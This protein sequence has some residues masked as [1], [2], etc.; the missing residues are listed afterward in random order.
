MSNT[1][2]GTAF[3][4]VFTALLAAAQ[5]R[6]LPRPLE[7]SAEYAAAI[8]DGRRAADGRPGPAA[9]TDHTRYVITAELEPALNLVRGHVAMTYGNRSG[10]AI[11]DLVIH[12]RQDLHRQGA[13]RNIEAEITGGMTIDRLTLN[14]GEAMHWVDGTVLTIQL[15]DE[16]AAGAEARVEMDFSFTVPNGEAPR[17]GRETDELF[18]LGYWYPQFAVHDDIEGWVAE[19]YLGTSEFYMPYGDYEVAFTVPA[20]YLVQATGTLTNA[21]EVLTAAT[22]ERLAAAATAKEPVAIITAEDHAAGTVTAAADNGARLTWRFTAT[23]VRDF[24]ISAA[25]CYLWDAVAAEVGDR[26]GDGKPD[27][28]LVNT[29]YRP[30]ARTY[31]RGARYA[32][33]AIEWMSR[34]IAPYPWP[35]ATVVE[36]ILG[37][38]M[39]YPMIVLCGDVPIPHEL[40]GLIAHELAH[41]WFPMLVG[42]NEKANA[43]QDE[44][45]VEFCTDL[46][47][48]DHDG[49]PPSGL[50][51]LAEYRFYADRGIDR[52]PL[53]R[54]SDHLVHESSYEFNGYT[55]PA[56]L[57]HQ[58]AGMF[59]HATVLGALSRYAAAWQYRHPRP[60]DFFRSMNAALGRDLDWYWSGWWGETWTL[61]HAIGSVRPTEDGNGTVVEIEDRGNAFL[62]AMVEVRYADGS[63][64]R[65]TV[66]ESTW[67]A[68]ARSATLVFG[69]DVDEVT[70][71]PQQTSLDVDPANNSWARTR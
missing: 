47:R 16:L 19:Q 32:S 12:L 67:L 2:T 42:S 6:P 11:E 10:E 43:W 71:D 23:G 8:A 5:D 40:Q 37:G 62:P 29:L 24:A 48:A 15:R 65:Q 59:D 63:T 66:S 39:E 35:H 17:M 21:G 7:V 28:C 55:K 54:H 20:G 68:G 3:A 50:R 9:W 49:H 18:F 41:M 58:L 56:A 4:V 30:E 38:G 13:R 53:L 1:C 60:L 64:A 31:A 22:R 70:I 14:G 69:P 52:E 27:R 61:D 44:G 57:L 51:R 34:H 46:I 25:S 45:L 26:D 33:H 36:G